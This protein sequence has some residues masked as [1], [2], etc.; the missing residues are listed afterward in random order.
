MRNMLMKKRLALKIRALCFLLIDSYS[1]SSANH[2]TVR[3]RSKA[4]LLPNFTVP[5]K[6]SD[7]T[8]HGRANSRDPTV[9][10]FLW[11]YNVLRFVSPATAEF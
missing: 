2:S 8:H 4:S 7:K 10:V 5:S 6:L 3:D 11:P 9:F 1:C